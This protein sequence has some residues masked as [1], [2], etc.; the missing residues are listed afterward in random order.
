MCY[1]E[2]TCPRCSSLNIKKNGKTVN[3]KQR[4]L[5]KDCR[6]QFITRYPWRGYQGAWRALI[7]PM[8]LN[9]SGIRDTVRVLGMSLNTVLQTI[10]AA[11]AQAPEP[12][13]P[14]RVEDLEIDE[15][16]SSIQSKKQQQWCWYGWDRQRIQITA[17]VL[18][19]RTDASCRR[20][21]QQHTACRVRTFHTDDW[22]S[23]RKYLP[24]K[25]HQIHKSGSQHIER[26][27][28]DFRTRIKRLQRRTICFS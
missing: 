12:V 22:Q 19:R 14:L 10:R 11:A 26:R 17:F 2:I 28:L 6:R 20:L 3:Q 7:V 21:V 4:C 27:N 15:F 23:Y 16:W 1:E 13:P 24:P 18:G 25:K 9:G 5:C 8:A